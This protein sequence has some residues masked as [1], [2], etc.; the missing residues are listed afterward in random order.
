M[1][2]VFSTVIWVLET[3]TA[4]AFATGF[5]TAP[6]TQS[7]RE[8]S[9]LESHNPQFTIFYSE[10][11]SL[12]PTLALEKLATSNNPFVIDDSAG[13][14]FGP[15]NEALATMKQW[16]V[17]QNILN[18]SIPLLKTEIEKILTERVREIKTR[19]EIRP[20]ALDQDVELRKQ[21]V[22]LLNQELPRL[23][24][25]LQQKIN[26]LPRR[27]AFL[28]RIWAWDKNTR[29]LSNQEGPKV[30]AYALAAGM[31]VGGFANIE[32]AGYAR[33]HIHIFNMSQ[34]A[35]ERVAFVGS[36]TL[37]AASLLVSLRYALSAPSLERYL[38]DIKSID[39][40]S[41]TPAPIRIDAV[42]SIENHLKKRSDDFAKLTSL[43][44]PAM[45][46]AD[47]R[48]KSSW[49]RFLW[50]KIGR[51]SLIVYIRWHLVKA[52]IAHLEVRIAEIEDYLTRATQLE[53]LTP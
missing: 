31:I 10:T 27:E 53:S 39:R 1:K 28:E 37:W 29:S 49:T 41:L 21:A 24:I 16:L 50:S 48:L 17:S 40:I 34:K 12:L 3:C 7:L 4:S 18:E 11:I 46:A 42:D 2:T 13:S 44:K 19:E 23:K 51:R 6:C 33:D 8:L 32:F 15:L 35:I 43:Y 14:E 38:I 47:L 26:Q 5:A 52:Q 20:K 9:F 25:L 36:M 45:A 30:L 22:T